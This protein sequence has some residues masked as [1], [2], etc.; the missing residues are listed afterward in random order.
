MLRRVLIIVLML[1]VAFGPT[2]GG[3]AATV[4]LGPCANPMIGDGDE[5]AQ[6]GHA[7]SQDDRMMP[8]CGGKLGCVS[9]YFLAPQSASLEQVSWIRSLYQLQ[10]AHLSGIGIEPEL[11]PPIPSA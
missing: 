9:A 11:S 5:M 2:V 3:F 10:T 6:A 8:G 1:T 7:Q 4:S